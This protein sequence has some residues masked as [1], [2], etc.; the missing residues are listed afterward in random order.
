M[1]AIDDWENELVNERSRSIVDQAMLTR[2]QGFEF[3]EI[4]T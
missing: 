3:I 4:P 2:L 1:R